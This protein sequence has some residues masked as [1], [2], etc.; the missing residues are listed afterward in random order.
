MDIIVTKHH[1]GKG[2]V[3]H[4]MNEVKQ[5]ASDRKLD[6]V[7]L[8]VFASNPAVDFYVKSGYTETNKTMVYKLG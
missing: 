8:T 1:Q 6:Y 2:I 5:W 7:E 3:T 4:L